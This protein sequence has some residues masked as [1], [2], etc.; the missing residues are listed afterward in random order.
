MDEMFRSLNS[1]VSE[2][3]QFGWGAVGW[4]VSAQLKNEPHARVLCIMPFVFEIIRKVE[5]GYVVREQPRR[6]TAKV[7]R[8]LFETSVSDSW[9]RD[10]GTL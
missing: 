6:I 4:T 5:E 9:I 7:V 2:G 8:G 10:A 3:L 1:R